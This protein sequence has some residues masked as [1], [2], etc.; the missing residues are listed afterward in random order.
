MHSFQLAKQQPSH[1]RRTKFAKSLNLQIS[2]VKDPLFRRRHQPSDCSCVACIL[3]TRKNMK[4]CSSF[5]EIESRA[6]VVSVLCYGCESWIISKQLEHQ[7]NCFG[8]KCYREMVGISLM[9]R[10]TNEELYNR[11]RLPPMIKIILKW[12]LTWLGHALCMPLNCS[13]AVDVSN[14][15]TLAPRLLS[16]NH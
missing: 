4:I 8:N 13:L 12:Q 7:L 16:S 1:S 11:V 15:A 5:S 2:R 14:Q 3:A 6:S 9:D 10:V